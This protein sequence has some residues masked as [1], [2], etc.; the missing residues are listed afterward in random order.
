MKSGQAYSIASKSSRILW[1]TRCRLTVLTPCTAR[2]ESELQ[3]GC[4]GIYFRLK[5]MMHIADS[6]RKETSTNLHRSTLVCGSSESDYL[7]HRT[8]S[9]HQYDCRHLPHHIKAHPIL[10]PQ[11]KR[12]LKCPKF[13]VATVLELYHASSRMRLSITP[14]LPGAWLAGTGH[15]DV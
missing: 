7:Q 14:M 1:R 2:R 6:E 11:T 5:Y 8:P 13:E 9:R 15:V 3:V 12:V 10:G 4:K